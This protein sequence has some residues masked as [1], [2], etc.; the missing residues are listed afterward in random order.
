[1]IKRGATLLIFVVFLVGLAL[2]LG[3]AVAQNASPGSAEDPLVTKSYVDQFLIPQVVELKAGQSIIGEAGTQFLIRVGSTY[4]LADPATTK[5]GIADLTG[6]FDLK[7]MEPV[8]LNHHLVVPRSD[9]R[10]LFAQTDVV[11]VVWGI[12]QIL[13]D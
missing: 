11:L 3:Q 1:M 10:G 13:G 7:H 5:G 12:Y 9:G 8:S 6:G 4:C 2:S